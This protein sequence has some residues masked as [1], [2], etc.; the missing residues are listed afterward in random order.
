MLITLLALWGFAILLMLRWMQRFA[1][2]DPQPNPHSHGTPHCPSAD[3]PKASEPPAKI[4]DRTDRP[5]GG[6]LH[7]DH[8]LAMTCAAPSSVLEHQPIALP[9]T[10][11]PSP[12]ARSDQF[13]QRQ[14]VLPRL[15]RARFFRV[16]ERGVRVFEQWIPARDDE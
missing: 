8:A 1:W 3:A 7:Q 4:D 9:S 11:V 6:P 12:R 14:L 5:Q 2:E 16:T 15:R 13:E 10:R